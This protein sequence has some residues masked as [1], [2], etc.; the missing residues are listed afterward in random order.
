M[1]RLFG[2]FRIYED[3]L[4]I[5]PK[6][7]VLSVG[8]KGGFL[9]RR[10]ADKADAVYAVDIDTSEIESKAGKG[11]RINISKGDITKGLDFPDHSFDKI[12]FTEVMEHLPK[13]AEAMALRE[14]R[15]LLKDDGSL[16]FSTPNDHLLYTLLD[17]IWWLGR[18]EHYSVRGVGDLLSSA[19][20]ET[21]KTFIGGGLIQAL[22]TPLF[23]LIC[24]FGM[25]DAFGDGF[26]ERAL[27]GEYRKP[28][29]CT[30]IMRA[31]PRED[32]ANP[33]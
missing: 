8:S 3:Y 9:E 18:H 2:R 13:G 33:R 23:Y 1:E 16:V 27:D 21:S 12:I 6:D 4:D 20:F 28:G 15:R 26:F 11:M 5:R 24:L 17:P 19:G 7:R 30:I 22:T 31:K 32:E 29:F 25:H 14:I 10:I